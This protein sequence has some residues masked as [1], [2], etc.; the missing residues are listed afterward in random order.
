MKK[1]LIERVDSFGLPLSE[2]VGKSIPSSSPVGKE[3]TSDE[4]FSHWVATDDGVEHGDKWYEKRIEKFPRWKI[5]E[6]NPKDVQG[7]TN[8]KGQ[9]EIVYGM[10]DSDEEDVAQQYSHIDPSHLPL[11][12]LEPSGNKWKWID[13]RHR[14]RASV[15]RG[16]L[17]MK[18]LVPA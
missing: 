15:I 4:V 6:V 5:A 8:S 7:H 1:N 3:F 17:K 13:G 14:S 2:S 18:A 16:D 9:N 12:I 10:A 11:V